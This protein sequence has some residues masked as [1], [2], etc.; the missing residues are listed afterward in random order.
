M[1][2]ALRNQ[3]RKFF[4]QAS[5]ISAKPIYGTATRTA[6]KSEL[7]FGVKLRLTYGTQPTSSEFY[8]HAVVVNR[9]GKWEIAELRPETTGR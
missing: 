6:D 2:D 8:Y 1:P 5:H 7:R 3:L 9:A 4:D